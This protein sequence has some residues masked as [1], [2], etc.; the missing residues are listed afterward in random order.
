MNE[1][2][3]L[4]YPWFVAFIAAQPERAEAPTALEDALLSAV[5]RALYNPRHR[6]HQEIF[7]F[8]D[9]CDAKE[10]RYEHPSSNQ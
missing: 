2:A 7:G 5:E 4:K 10:G 6:L 9:A 1:N 3:R 8:Y